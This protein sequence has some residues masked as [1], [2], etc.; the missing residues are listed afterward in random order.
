MHGGAPGSG[1]PPRQ[2]ECAKAWSLYSR[3]NCRTAAHPRPRE[4][5]AQADWADQVGGISN[6]RPMAATIFTR[7]ISQTH[8]RVGS[9]TLSMEEEAAR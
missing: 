1:A 6:L 7:A 4:A 8:T 9:N 5:D 3:R 2:P